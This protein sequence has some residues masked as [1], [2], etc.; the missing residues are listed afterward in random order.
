MEEVCRARFEE[1]ERSFPAPSEHTALPES[2]HV[3]QCGNSLN[4]L[5]LGFS[6]GFITQAGLTKSLSAG[7]ST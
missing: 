3:Q 7:G 1:T 6:G 2:P 4:S 5:L